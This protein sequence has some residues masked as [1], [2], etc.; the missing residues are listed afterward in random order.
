MRIAIVSLFPEMFSAVTEYGVSGRAVLKG[1]VQVKCWNPRD[2]AHDK[3]QTVDDRPYGG[4]PGMLMMMQPLEDAIDAATSWAE[5]GLSD[6]D[7]ANEAN[8][9]G[10]DVVYL[11]P[12][13]RP[14]RQDQAVG[15]T[16]RNLVL[17]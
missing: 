2:F 8:T 15:F 9:S 17:I 4:G 14:L 1:L 10:A 16:E 12:Q 13:G 11:S 7:I 3:H 6:A 5:S